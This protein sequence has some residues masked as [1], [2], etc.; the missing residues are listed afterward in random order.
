MILNTKL[1][2][3]QV[4][5]KK[6]AK[7]II[8]EDTKDPYLEKFSFVFNDKKYIKHFQESALDQVQRQNQSQQ[9]V[10]TPQ[11]KTQE[12]IEEEK[13]EKALEKARAHE[14]K[15]IGVQTASSMLGASAG[16]SLV[17]YGI[18][19]AMWAGGKAI[20]GIKHLGSG[21]VDTA[22]KIAGGVT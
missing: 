10:Q 21:V 2:F 1:I 8:Q 14:L 18:R 22:T 13:R 12:D 15:R 20:E 9:Q 4:I 7:E 11:Q 19:G 3:E 16:R 6:P 5:P 17:D